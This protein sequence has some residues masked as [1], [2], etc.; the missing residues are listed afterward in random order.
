MSLSED[1]IRAKFIDPKIKINGWNESF[2]IRNYPITDDRFIIIDDNY[3]KLKTNLKADYV[4]N[5]KGSIISVLEAKAENENLEKH[6]SQLQNYAKKLDVLIS[7][8]SNGKD[9]FCYDRRDLT[10]SKVDDYLNPEN[11]FNIYRDFKKINININD[12]NKFPNYIFSNKSLRS[13][14]EV[15]IK[16]TVEEISSGKKKNLLTMAT[17]SGKTLVAFQIAWKLTQSKFLNRILFLTDRIFLRDQAYK[18]FAPFKIGLEETRF[19]IEEG[20]FNKNRN[21]YFTNYQSLYSNFI[22]KKIPKDFFDLIIIDECHRSRYGDWGQI[23]EYF[24]NAYQ[25]GLTATPLREDNIDVY[26]YFGK[27]IFEYSFAQG[28]EDGYLVPYKIHKINTNL[29]KEGLQT[30]LAEEIIYDDNIDEDLI[31]S[32]YIPAEFERIV[33]IPDQIELFCKKILQIL[34]QNYLE[35]SIIFCVDKEHAQKVKDIFNKVTLNENYAAKIVSEEKDDMADFSDKERPYP[36][37]ATT[38]DLLSTGIDIPHLK[39]IIFMRSINSKVLFKQIIGRGAR[40]FDGKGFFRI[41]DFTSATRLI[42]DWEIPKKPEEGQIEKEI[43]PFNKYV[44]GYVFDKESKLPL[45]NVEAIINVGRWKANTFSDQYGKFDLQKLPSNEILSLSTSYPDYKKKSLKINNKIINDNITIEIA[46]LS[47]QISKIQINGINVT[48]E[49]ETIIEFDGDNI[50]FKEYIKK[51]KEE[52]LSRV[53]TKEAV[54]KI[55]IDSDKKKI[56][57]E[58]LKEKN[59]DLYLIKQLL[60]NTDVDS[61]DIILHLAFNTPVITRSDRVKNFIINND[62]FIKAYG[63]DF[64]NSLLEV[65]DM[66]LYSGEESLTPEI[67]LIPNM[68]KHKKI[69]EVKYPDGVNGFMYF[70]KKGLYNSSVNFN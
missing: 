6:L 62:N 16:K 20:K 42:D 14:Q 56:F 69:I 57:L 70:L 38:V 36:A 25:L 22:Y 19:K 3:K 17:G 55:W 13:Y 23:L 11:I 51:S 59:I 8:I 52:I 39:N 48:I 53:I 50:N 68:N 35:K 47:K 41:I 37:V 32:H 27:P 49:E 33:T 15:A 31:K 65:L 67:F 4:L 7:Y 5:Y 29:Y 46:P 45:K 21:I 61:L 40:L 43:E 30:D 58:K 66:Y 18:D 28:V 10:I 12:P 9:I 44:S 34:G 24:D 26:K 63:E 1:D 60:N 64:K 54:N 2:I